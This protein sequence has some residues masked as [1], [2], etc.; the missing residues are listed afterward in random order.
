MKP[1]LL[2]NIL[3]APN[4]ITKEGI[5]F[6][7]NHMKQSKKTPLSVFDPEK[8]NEQ[9]GIQW[10]TDN[11]FRTTNHCDIDPVFEDIKDLF[12]NLVTNIINPF[13]EFEIRDSEVPQ[14]LHYPQGGHYV[15]HIDGYAEWVN[16]DGTKFGGKAQKEI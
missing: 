1:N 16:P 4:V 15:P 13:Y 10:I 9:Q 14:L 6:L 2:T 3:I 11:K 5:D 8:S 7:V 12:K